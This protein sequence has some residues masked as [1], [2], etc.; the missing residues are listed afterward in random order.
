[1]KH[2]SLS[3]GRWLG[4]LL[5]FIGIFP[6]AVSAQR[7][8]SSSFDDTYIFWGYPDDYLSYQAQ[9]AYPLIDTMLQTYPPTLTPDKN[10]QLALVTLDQLLHEANY[11]RREAFYTFVNDR[12]TTMLAKV[13]KPVPYGV[14]V[15]KLY[16][17][18]FVLKT[19]DITIAIDIVPGGTAAKPFLS[20]PV[21]YEIA[22][23]CDALLVTNADSQHANRSVAD[24]FMLLGKTVIVPDGL[25]R[26]AE[27]GLQYASAEVTPTMDMKGTTL[28][29]L[30]GHR[31][32]EKNNIYI[33]DF[34]GRGIVAHTGAQDNDADWEWID[35]IHN[36]FNVDILLTKSANIRLETMLAGFQPRLVITSHE[37][38]MENTVDR[39]ES[40]WT[41]QKR[42]QSLAD[43]NIPNVLMTW[44]ETY[45]YADADS[46]KISSSRKV[47][48][49][50]ILYIERKG[51][52]YTPAGIKV[53]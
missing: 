38:A 30:D 9:I 15:F 45:D 28:Y 29:V 25:W 50:G 2:M 11:S 26:D 21:I 27:A 47:L 23:R 46:K 1:M 34:L 7:A 19:K 12:M 17:S 5:V 31:G 40:Y 37:N 24:V 18:G 20:E 6:F 49:N 39:R 33:M 4:I 48:R 10:R 22:D 36:Q 3:P 53:K 8:P 16:N 43:L 52:L 32:K 41:T 35:E 13:D 14:R 51:S 44:G 42:V